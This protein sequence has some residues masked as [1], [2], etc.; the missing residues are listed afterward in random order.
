MYQ[1]IILHLSFSH[2][3][4]SNITAVFLA[5]WLFPLQILYY[6]DAKSIWDPV[7]LKFIL[8]AV[9]INAIYI[10]K[11]VLPFLLIGS[12][13]RHEMNIWQLLRK[14]VFSECKIIALNSLSAS[15]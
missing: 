14:Y 6:T 12:R 10:F 8:Q 11:L 13:E 5:P 2:S 7:S 4:I 1:C 3:S 15:F 9:N